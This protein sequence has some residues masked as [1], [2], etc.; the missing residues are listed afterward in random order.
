MIL[1][2]GGG[3]FGATAA[4]ALARR[5][6]DVTLVSPHP[7]PHPRAATTDISKIVRMDY[8][9]DALYTDLMARALPLW[10]RDPL[11]HPD[12]FLIL[13]RNALLPGG[14]EHDSFATLTRRGHPLTRMNP[15][16]LRQSH[17]AWNA[18]GYPDGYHN[19]RAGWA[20]S[21]AVLARTLAE[22]VEAGVQLVEA[23]VTGL[24]GGDVV[25]GVRT[26]SGLRIT[27]ST[28]L[29]ATGAWTTKLLPS[30]SGLLAPTAQPVLHFRPHDPE[31]YTAPAFPT[32]AADISTTGWYGFPVNADGILKV[33]NH[34]PGIRLDP[35]APRDVGP[36]VEPMFRAFLAG[37]FPSLARAPLVE[38]RLCLY[39]DSID[40]DFLIDRH[41]TRSGLLVAAGG[42]GH[43][44]KFAPILGDLIADVVQGAAPIPRF[45]WRTPGQR[46]TEQARCN[47]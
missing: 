10:E 5:G 1:V 35:D 42:S 38:S 7:L 28:V 33:A 3:I 44:F 16:R 40:G 26:A 39:S 9:A 36:Q 13:S 31:R 29:V 45:A 8:G 27:A 43:G 12:G 19:P 41:P 30:L 6:R 24:L 17:P 18:D 37:T 2:V 15:T 20:N 32:W 34:G 25:T 47:A 22:A 11:Y 14:F 4:L 21:G 46:K 23:Q